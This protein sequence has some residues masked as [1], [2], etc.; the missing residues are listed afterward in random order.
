MS[1]VRPELAE[2]LTR[3]REAAV[4]AAL[5]V[6][7][8]WWAW[9]AFGFHLWLGIAVSIVGAAILLEGIRRARFRPGSGGPG[10]VE[11]DERQI[12]YFGPE[13]G[14]AVSIDTLARVMILTTDDAPGGDDAHW[15]LE[16][17]SGAMLLIPASAAGAEQLFDAIAALPGADHE[18]VLRAMG[19]TVRKRHVVWEMAHRRLH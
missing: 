17:E 16:D 13:T 8:A 14:G 7:G 2:A 12:T 19:S 18:A 1:F 9:D 3:W 4:G 6:L 10:V 15:M 11:V 5:V